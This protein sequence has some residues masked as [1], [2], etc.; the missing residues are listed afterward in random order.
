MRRQQNSLRGTVTGSHSGAFG[1]GTLLLFIVDP[2]GTPDLTSLLQRLAG[3][4]RDDLWLLR[5][6]ALYRLALSVVLALLYFSGEG[7][8][9]LG[10]SFPGL[11]AMV[12]IIYVG[13]TATGGIALSFSAA[14]SKQNHSFLM[15]FVDIVAF[16]LLTHASGG[17]ISG[18]G[19]L[20][21]ISLAFG[22]LLVRERIPLLMA[23]LASLGV[24]TEQLYADLSNLFEQ[25]AYTQAGLLGVAYFA[26][27]TLAAVFAQRL[28]Q[29]EREIER[30]EIDLANLQ[31]VNEYVIQHM[32]TGILVI[33][34]EDRIRMI[35]E[36]ARRML[37]QPATW[38]GRSLTAISPGLAGQLGQWQRDHSLQRVPFRPNPEGRELKAGF[39]AL[40][41]RGG[42]GTVVFLEDA[43]ILDQ[44][45]QQMKLASLGRLTASIAHEIRNPLGAISHAG[46]LLAE[47]PDLP[48]GERRLT[49]IIGT[50]SRRMNDIIE[51]V[52]QLA[53]RDR[54]NPRELELGPLVEEFTELFL[55]HH[56]GLGKQLSVNVSPLETRVYAD[57]RQII[58]VLTNLCDNAISHFNR[59]AGE[60]RLEMRGGEAREYG[61][62]FLEVID[63]GGGIPAPVL[64]EVFEPFF[65]TS[66]AGTGLGLYIA[67]ELC[68]SNR[69]RLE[70]ADAPGGGSCFRLKFP[71]VRH[72]ERQA[73]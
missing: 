6:F 56:P 48:P 69:V 38:I 73:D 29:H 72:G 63:N 9:L 55:Q 15:V 10:Q 1:R 5:V 52:L 66:N 47:S 39:S 23:A 26:I 4:A 53:R 13:L 2:L 19:I 17:V 59:E 16:T 51:T 50:H 60:L 37:G 22:S 68:E 62:P 32:L 46:Q 71:G 34:A 44:Q 57:P 49:E 41:E 3:R 28:R 25:T 30:R 20:I 70:Y 18:L 65:T 45:A 58:Q 33:D 12:S 21:A 40:G 43:A 27:A 11:F 64:K 24:L 14:I 61:G 7:P 31:Q 54:S 42:A 8:V 35:N 36:S 67:R